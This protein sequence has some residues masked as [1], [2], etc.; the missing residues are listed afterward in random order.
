MSNGN[1]IGD[2]I[3]ESSITRLSLAVYLQD[4]FSRAGTVGRTEVQIQGLKKRPVQNP[5]LYYLFLDLPPGDYSL[6]VRSDYYFDR[7]V[8]PVT[9]G[10]Q[11]LKDPLVIELLPLPSYP[12]PPG[13]TLVRGILKDSSQNPVPDARLSWNNGKVESMTTGIGEFVIYFTDLT[14]EDIIEDAAKGKKFVKGDQDSTLN[15]NVEYGN[16]TSILK[17]SDVEVGKTNSINKI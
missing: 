15:I 17:I 10:T 7:D 5:S 3:L 12:F 2:E 9:I 11:G 4:K 16:V 13:E 14:E 6:Q 8:G 1:M